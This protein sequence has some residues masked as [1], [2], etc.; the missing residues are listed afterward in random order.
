[1]L[2]V[3]SDGTVVVKVHEPKLEVAKPTEEENVEGVE[4]EKSE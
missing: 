4:E 3:A 1:M 2:D